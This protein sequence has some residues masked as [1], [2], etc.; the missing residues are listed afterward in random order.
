[1]S[2]TSPIRFRRALLIGAIGWLA[3]EI[4]LL[5]LIARKLGWGPTLAVVSLKGGIGLVA[6][7][8]GTAW[9]WRRVRAQSGT[10]RLE[11]AAVPLSAALLVALPG[12]LPALGAL[13]LAAPSARAALMRWIRTRGAAPDPLAI[14]LSPQEWREKGRRRARLP[15][16]AALETKRR[17]V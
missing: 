17:S 7:A 1:M 11:A 8:L 4:A 14:D 2:I 16:K 3:L 15:R 12:F 6:L 10:A 9:A 13:A 5:A